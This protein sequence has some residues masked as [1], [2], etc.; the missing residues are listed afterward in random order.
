MRDAVENMKKKGITIG[1]DYGSVI[2]QVQRNPSSG[3]LVSS[4]VKEKNRQSKRVSF[5]DDAPTDF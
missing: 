5:I 1:Y 3:I 4:S 2:R